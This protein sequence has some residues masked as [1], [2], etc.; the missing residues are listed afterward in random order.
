M[1]GLAQGSINELFKTQLLT[2]TKLFFIM[3]KSSIMSKMSTKV[4][5]VANINKVYLKPYASTNIPAT[6]DPKK[7]PK[8]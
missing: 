2:V 7:I 8:A 4:K 5:L 6:V 1:R 3:V